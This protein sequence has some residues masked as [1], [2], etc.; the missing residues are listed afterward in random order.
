MKKGS[1]VVR[2]I[3]VGLM[4]LAVVSCSF[5]GASLD[6]LS[7]ASG[8]CGTCREGEA[9]VEG[10]CRSSC[11]AGQVTCDSVCVAT[12][13]DP[14]HCGDCSVTCKADEVCG[15]GHCGSTCPTGQINCDG[16]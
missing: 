10:Q 2:A 1:G 9:C 5:L 6:A 7:S 14:H 16:S 15:D 3:C 12:M 13:N 8:G 4:L 11:L